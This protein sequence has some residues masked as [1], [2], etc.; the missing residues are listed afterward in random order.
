VQ[1]K[2]RAFINAIS[3]ER[4]SDRSLKV[5]MEAKYFRAKGMSADGLLTKV[6]DVLKNVRV[7]AAG[8]RGVGTPLHQI[9]SGRSLMDMWNEFILKKWNA[10]QGTIYAPSNS[11]SDDELMLDVQDGCWLINTTTNLLIAVLVH[12]CNP[13][14]IVDP[15]TVRTGPTREILHKDSQKDS[16]ERRE[17]G[18]IL[19]H[20]AMGRQR[21]EESML[22]SKAQL[23]AKTIDSGTIDQVKEQLALLSQFKDSFVKVQ[24]RH[25]GGKGEDDFDQTT[26]DLLLELPFMKKRRILGADT[27]SE[28]SNLNDSQTTKSNN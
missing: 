23:M 25:I 6:N 27:N 17:R 16:V 20:H 9:P 28:I 4:F 18:R 3:L 14:V 19:E 10:M 8:I 7:M 2:Y 15:T 1:D 22:E 13:D 5:T 12:R 26:H 11:S 24:N 21:A